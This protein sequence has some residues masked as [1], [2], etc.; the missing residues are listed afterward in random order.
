MAVAALL[1]AVAG[2]V[3]PFEGS[4]LIGFLPGPTVFLG[5]DVTATPTPPGCV[6]YTLKIGVGARPGEVVKQFYITAQFPGNVASYKF[7]AAE[8][9]ISGSRTIGVGAFV[10]GEDQNGECTV[11]QVALTP[12][13]DVTATQAGPR[14]V[15]IRGAN[16]L[17]STIVYGVFAMSKKEPSSFNNPSIVIAGGYYK[18]ELFGFTI[19]KHSQEL[20]HKD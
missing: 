7:G 3:L 18:Y 13:P 10:L 4:T 17:P 15:Q 19:T 6:A 11:Q 1:F 5:L 8:A 14:M 12:S 20:P 16:V 9:T 2:V